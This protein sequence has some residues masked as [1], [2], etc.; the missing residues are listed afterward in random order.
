MDFLEGPPP[1]VFDDADCSQEWCAP[2][3]CL[4]CT[5][6]VRAACTRL[7]SR[8]VGFLDAGVLAMTVEVF[9]D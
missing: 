1:G 9:G 4:R 5:T 6:D 3:A 2:H 8:G 7:L